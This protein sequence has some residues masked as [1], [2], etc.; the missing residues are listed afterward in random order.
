MKILF[1]NDYRFRQGGAET[2][3]RDTASALTA[4][5][6]DVRRLSFET[7]IEDRLSGREVLTTFLSEKHALTL[8]D[9]TIHTYCPDII[10]LNNYVKYTAVIGEILRRR[11]IPAVT[12]VHDYYAVPFP[13]SFKNRLKALFRPC[14]KHCSHYIIPSRHYYT[15][16][17]K[18]KVTGV[19]HIPHFIR[20]EKWPYHRDYDDRRAELLFVGRLER[21]KGAHILLSAVKLLSDRFPELRLTVVGEGREVPRLQKTIDATGL[22]EKVRLIGAVEQDR[23]ADYYRKSSVVVMPSVVDEILGLVGPEAMA[24]GIPVVASDVAGIREWCIHGKTGLLTAPGDAAALAHTLQHLLENP[25]LRQRLREQARTFVEQRFSEQNT[26]GNLI[27]YYRQILQHA[28]RRPLG[29][30]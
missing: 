30:V 17:N 19:R 16:L 23:V 26:I 29:E 14:L 24:S 7:R 2:Y 20:L 15:E 6:L 12:T 21:I 8:L 13:V 5:G 10:H 3:W 11:P 28:E 4:A 27:G 22:S 9:E 1:Y 18:R 25:P